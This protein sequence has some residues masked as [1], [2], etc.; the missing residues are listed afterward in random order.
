MGFWI[1]YQ[2][3]KPVVGGL[4]WHSRML[5]LSK[6]QIRDIRAILSV[7]LDCGRNQRQLDDH[8]GVLP[9]L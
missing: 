4:H 3:Q 6:S 8:L 9:S 2:R 1:R 5:N 7:K